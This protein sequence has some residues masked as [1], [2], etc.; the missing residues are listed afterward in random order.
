MEG[1]V[2]YG[3]LP[4]VSR[5]VLHI[6]NG[7]YWLVP[8]YGIAILVVTAIVRAL[9]HPM[10]RKMQIGMAKMQKIQ[11]MVAE[12]QKKYPNDKQKLTQEQLALWRKYGVNPM[13]GCWPM[14]LQ[15]PVLFALFGALRAAI[16]LRH[17]GFLWINDLS[18][19]DRLFTLPFALPLMGT[20]FNIL[21]ILSSVAMFFSQKSATTAATSDQARQQQAMMKFMPIMLLFFFY[22]MPSGLC[23]YFFA[24]MAIGILERKL[25]ERKTANMELRPVGEKPKRG[26]SRGAAKGS[27]ETW[28]GKLQRKV[29][30]MERKGR[31]KPG[32]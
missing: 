22:R 15:L 9:L 20:E 10:T 7:V 13:G 8:N 27:D 26:G 23:L 25:V 12:L 21:P 2:E 19:P 32:K 18:M 5:I 29:D 1:L 3:M 4:S 17:A 14:F 24:S 16:E 31:G 11:P 28:L 6:L 30:Q